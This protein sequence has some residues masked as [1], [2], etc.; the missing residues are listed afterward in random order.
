MIK[1]M[2]LGLLLAF[3]SMTMCGLAQQFAANIPPL[4]GEYP[5][6][7]SSFIMERKLKSL[8]TSVMYKSPNKKLDHS[9]ESEMFLF[10]KNGNTVTWT[11]NNR[12]GV[13][14]SIDY[15]LNDDNLLATEHIKESNAAYLKSFA[16]NEKGLVTQI[17]LANAHT[18][19]TI[20]Q[21]NFKYEYFGELQY[22]KYW[23]NDELLT[24][25]YTVVDL[26]ELGRK[27]EE[28]TRFI[29]GASRETNYYSY[30]HNLLISYS[31][32]DKEFTR[33]E[34]KYVI[35]HNKRGVVLDM[36]KYVDGAFVTRFEYLYEN[37]LL[38][39]ILQKNL[40]TQEIK[41]TKIKCEFY[42]DAG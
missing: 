34:V 29:R 9:T 40:R 10:D 2:K 4:M 18:A 17:L 16:Y 21:E 5:F 14:V 37:G 22:K 27:E 15:F 7:N 25:K 24:Y 26:D 20:I 33:R 13:E 36:N 19:K 35:N 6:F 1:R 39:A 31:H 23:L 32:N 3:L 42:G 41:I 11:K 12:I 30:K 8:S 28:R 38:I